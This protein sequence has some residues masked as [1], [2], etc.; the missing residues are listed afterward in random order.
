M[1]DGITNQ[2]QCSRWFSI[3]AH[4]RITGCVFFALIGEFFG[5]RT[6]VSI[7]QAFKPFEPNG[8]KFKVFVP[9]NR[10]NVTFE[11]FVHF[12]MNETLIT[13][14]K[15]CVCIFGYDTIFVND[16]QSVLGGAAW[17]EIGFSVPANITDGFLEV[18][19]TNDKCFGKV[20]FS[21]YVFQE[22]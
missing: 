7:Q 11:N 14:N 22:L 8:C 13:S 17:P 21:F 19:L 6:Q 16:F 20:K 15:P 5:I 1:G 12:G 3:P 10:I 4:Q 9:D 2:L 18:G